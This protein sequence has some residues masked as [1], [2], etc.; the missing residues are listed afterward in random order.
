MRQLAAHK[1]QLLG[2]LVHNGHVA[3]LGV[4]AHLLD[5]A[6]RQVDAEGVGLLVKQRRHALEHLDAH[7]GRRKGSDCC[8]EKCGQRA[9]SHS[10]CALKIFSMP[11]LCFFSTLEKPHTT[12]AAQTQNA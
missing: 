5:H 10:L 2:Q 7:I 8:D 11:A 12:A 9:R 4:L 6:D 3:Q 1:R